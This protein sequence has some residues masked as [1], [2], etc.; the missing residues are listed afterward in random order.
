MNIRKIEEKP[1]QIHRVEG[2]KI[3]TLEAAGD[4]LSSGAKTAGAAAGKTVT[5]QLE[6]GEEL[7]R[8]ALL[9]D[10]AYMPLRSTASAAGSGAKSVSNQAKRIKKLDPGK[11]LAKRSAKVTAKKVTKSAAKETAKKTAKETTKTAAQIAA[12][13]ST[14]VGGAVAGATAGTAIAPGAGTAIGFAA[15][16]A[17][18]QAAGEIVGNKIDK[19][20][21]R[22]GYYSRAMQFG[23]NMLKNDGLQ[24]DSV[25]EL[26][27]DFFLHG[28]AWRVK[29]Y[30]VLIIKFYAPV[31]S[32]VIL[33]AA[34]VAVVVS[35]LYNS[36]FALFMPT[37]GNAEETIISVA[38]EYVEAFEDEIATLAAE[39]AGCDDGEII[40]PDFEG[41]GIPS[42][43]HDIL[44]VYMVKY[45]IEEMATVVDDTAKARLKGVVDDMCFYTTSTVEETCEVEVETEDADGNTT[46]ETQT[47]TRTTL[48]VEVTLL[49]WQDMIEVYGFDEDEKEILEALMTSEY[50][51][52]IS[53]GSS[54][55]SVTSNMQ[56]S[57]TTAE[58][59]AI[60]ES[61]TDATRKA[62]V[63]FALSKVGLPYSQDLRDS[64]TAYDCSS[65][66]YYALK[67]AGID[68]SYEG[69]NS[70]AAEAQGLEAA[71]KAI[72][73]DK[74]QPGDLIFYSTS[75]N[76][77]Y[78]NITHVAIYVGD[79]KVVEALGTNYGVVYQDVR[80]AN[81][82][83]IASPY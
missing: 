12:A 66:A 51:A 14:S 26:V 36:P 23:I 59:N 1:M 52:L 81:I 61:I 35:A 18:G 27:R 79:G 71:G 37:W 62:A 73:Y 20:F 56:T 16:E 11:R 75:T 24:H 54:T 49:T 22:A 63:E 40:Y 25:L 5:D 76:G 78:K 72:T 3:K 30:A 41:Y 13:A 55:N 82:V 15:G 47:V 80:T 50:M 33:N 83:L 69:A 7:Q 10:T 42:N 32:V 8:A 31:L 44:A 57:L 67:A 77:R 60:T 38:S 39:H 29:H 45:G 65:L 64:G 6:G 9:M 68:I 17:I 34:L 70:A 4:R 21:H 43:Y 53:Y 74:L 28:L 2:P 58:V 46:T 48:R 19:T